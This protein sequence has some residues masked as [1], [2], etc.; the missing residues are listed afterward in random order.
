MSTELTMVLSIL[1][2]LIVPH[3][4]PFNLLVR[5]QFCYQFGNRVDGAVLRLKP[6][7][8]RTISQVIYLQSV[9]IHLLGLRRASPLPMPAPSRQEMVHNAFLIPYRISLHS[10]RPS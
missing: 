3:S 2:R 8:F 5:H 1:A 6:Q 10:Y 9:A 7:V 4:W